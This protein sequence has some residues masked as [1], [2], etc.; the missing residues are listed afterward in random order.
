M[1]QK[2]NLIEEFVLLSCLPFT[3]TLQGLAH[4]LIPI[5]VVIRFLGSFILLA[6]FIN[7]SAGTIV[8]FPTNTTWTDHMRKEII[9][10]DWSL[11][12]Q[13][14]DLLYINLHAILSTFL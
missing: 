13:L 11:I 4:I 9:I 14:N 7:N 10:I 6:E 12:D 5:L 3:H 2:M 1:N 8:I